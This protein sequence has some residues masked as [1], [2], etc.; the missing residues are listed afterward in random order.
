MQNM[1]LGQTT[2]DIRNCTLS[3]FGLNDWKLKR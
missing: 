3:T 2:Q 1:G